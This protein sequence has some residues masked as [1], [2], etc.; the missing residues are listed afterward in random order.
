VLTLRSREDKVRRRGGTDND[1][2]E[3]EGRRGCR[4]GVGLM[5]RVRDDGGSMIKIILVIRFE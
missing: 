2:S 3:G 1:A 5:I 4:G